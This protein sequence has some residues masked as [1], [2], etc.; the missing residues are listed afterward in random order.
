MLV[1]ED[2]APEYRRHICLGRIIRSSG[3]PYRSARMMCDVPHHRETATAATRAGRRR[4]EVLLRQ[5]PA[6]SLAAGGD[7]LRQRIAHEVVIVDDHVMAAPSDAQHPAHYAASF[8]AQSLIERH[9]I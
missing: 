3:S 2:M 5:V 1:E 9:S 8:V 4:P 7:E 6:V